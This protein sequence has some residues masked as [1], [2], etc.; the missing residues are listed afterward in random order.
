MVALAVIQFVWFF[1]TVIFQM[2]LTVAV[3]AMNSVVCSSSRVFLVL[4]F[5][6]AI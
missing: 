6:S 5:M 4:V 2:W 3:I 1:V